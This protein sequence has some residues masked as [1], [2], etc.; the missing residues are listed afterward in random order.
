MSELLG[1]TPEFCTL[2]ENGLAFRFTGFPFFSI[3]IAF[4]PVRP[5]ALDQCQRM[6]PGVISDVLE[7]L[8]ESNHPRS[9]AHLI[10]AW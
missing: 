3:H 5:A 1:P 8:P 4:V 10:Q 9:Q 2:P 7:T 6:I